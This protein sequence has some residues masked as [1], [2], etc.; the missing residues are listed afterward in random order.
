MTLGEMLMI[1]LVV[2]QWQQLLYNPL[3]IRDAN[4]TEYE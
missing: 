4:H 2:V 3:L 1:K